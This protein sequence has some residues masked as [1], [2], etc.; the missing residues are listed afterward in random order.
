VP[1]ERLLVFNLKEGGASS[2]IVR[3]SPVREWEF[4]NFNKRDA[5]VTHQESLL[6]G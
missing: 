6:V 3:S 1:S 5:F 4:P 2:W